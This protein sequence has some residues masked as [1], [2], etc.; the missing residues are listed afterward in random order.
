MLNFTQEN[1]LTKFISLFEKDGKC[2][3][4]QHAG[5]T[6]Q[7][8]TTADVLLKEFSGDSNVGC[9]LWAP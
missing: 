1:V 4:Y 8:T 7:T 3:W 6:I 5:T 2:C 9:S